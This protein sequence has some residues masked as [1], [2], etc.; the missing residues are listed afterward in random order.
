MVLETQENLELSPSY[1]LQLL[2]L[3]QLIRQSRVLVGRK[4]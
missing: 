2:V 4:F 1:L 3:V